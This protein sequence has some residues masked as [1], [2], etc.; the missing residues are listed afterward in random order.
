M[1][2]YVNFI[3]T[4]TKNLQKIHKKIKKKEPPKNVLKNPANQKEKD[5]EK[6]KVTENSKND[7][8][9]NNEMAISTHLSIKVN[10]LSATIR[11]LRLDFIQDV[12]PED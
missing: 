12:N 10:G 1:D 5:Q 9:K 7:H 3:V 8:E 4:T 6:K 2:I 11:R